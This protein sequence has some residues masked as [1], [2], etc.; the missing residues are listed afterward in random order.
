MLNKEEVNKI[1]QF[2]T[3]APLDFGDFDSNDTGSNVGFNKLATWKEH[4]KKE[5]LIKGANAEDIEKAKQKEETREKMAL[6]RNPSGLKMKKLTSTFGYVPVE[7]VIGAVVGISN[8]LN[9]FVFNSKNSADFESFTYTK[10]LDLIFGRDDSFSSTVKKLSPEEI[11]VCE[12]VMS[13]IRVSSPN[14]QVYSYDNEKALNFTEGR[15]TDLAK[16]VGDIG[17]TLIAAIRKTSSAPDNIKNAIKIKYEDQ[18]RPR[19]PIEGDKE[20]EKKDIQR[21]DIKADEKD[22]ILYNSFQKGDKAPLG[23]STNGA[24]TTKETSELIKKLIANSKG[25]IDFNFDALSEYVRSGRC[26]TSFTLGKIISVSIKRRRGDTRILDKNDEASKQKIKEAASELRALK[27]ELDG[28]PFAEATKKVDEFN[29]K[30]GTSQTIETIK[31]HFE[32]GNYYI[33]ILGETSNKQPFRFFVP[34]VDH[35]NHP[36]TKLLFDGLVVPTPEDYVVISPSEYKVKEGASI[37]G[38]SVAS[39]SVYGKQTASSDGNVY[40]NINII[41]IL[42]PTKLHS[43]RALSSRPKGVL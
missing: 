34:Y 4:V 43:G 26:H 42:V 9:S 28:M 24:G 23:L 20:N 14:I 33:D 35:L 32:P 21:T 5:P 2:L 6:G 19:L 22:D 13:H 40:L 39:V 15:V 37:N 11:Q 10:V 7:N 16:V 41:P 25:P 1:N 17:A 3:E 27:D 38:V 12:Y 30:H 31:K 8:K 36:T 29:R 18:E